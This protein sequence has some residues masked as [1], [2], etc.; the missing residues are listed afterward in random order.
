MFRNRF[1]CLFLSA[2]FL[3]GCTPVE[4]LPDDEPLPLTEE[5]LLIDDVEFAP[6]T[7]VLSAETGSLPVRL[8]CFPDTAEYCKI[9]VSEGNVSDAVLML[10]SETSFSYILPDS[11]SPT[12]S[13]SLIFFDDSDSE[14][15]SA[16]I[17]LTSRNHIEPDY[18]GPDSY[19]VSTIS[20]QSPA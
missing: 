3:Y 16:R 17:L 7:S 8:S 20:S 5:T 11:M 18:T 14:I 2:V 19:F 1:T 12:V 13:L 6:F 15:A 4:T 10:D 9:T